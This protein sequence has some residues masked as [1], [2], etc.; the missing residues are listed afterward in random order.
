M[1]SD[2]SRAVRADLFPNCRPTLWW[3]RDLSPAA[4]MDNFFTFGSLALIQPAW[5]RVS[6][7][8]DYRAGELYRNSLISALFAGRYEGEM[9]YGEI[10]KFGD[11]GIGAFNHLDGEMVGF[12]GAFYHVRA[13]GSVRPITADQKTPFA[14]VTV[15]RPDVEF[16][17]QGRM[18]KTGVQAMIEDAA[19]ANLFSAVRVD[20]KFEEIRTRAF[21]RRANS[22]ARLAETTEDETERVLT[23]V[24]G[25]LAG[26]RTPEYAQGTGVADFHMHFLRQDKQRGGYAI[27]YRLRAGKVQ[28]CTVRDLRVELP[29]PGEF[30]MANFEHP[31]LKE[32]T[33]T[34]EGG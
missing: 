14:I 33:K 9:T 26:F 16:E 4:S 1:R 22:S 25:T 11:F 29:I 8:E 19:S 32:K 18:T 17:V 24:Q 6:G 20:G 5:H 31:E 30:H 7:S 15:F 34:A 21:R 2:G 3:N 12:D 27:D 13:D 28:I 10:R 23:Y